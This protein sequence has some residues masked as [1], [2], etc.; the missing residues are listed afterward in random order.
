MLGKEHPVRRASML[1]AALADPDLDR[2]HPALNLLQGLAERGD[3]IN[4]ATYVQRT[5]L[6]GNPPRHCLQAYSAED[7]YSPVPTQEAL[8]WALYL[9]QVTNGNEALAGLQVQETPAS[10]NQY[11]DGTYVTGI[12]ALYEPNSGADGHDVLF[13]LAIAQKQLSHF[14]A[15][16]V[17]DGTPTVVIP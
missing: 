9:D 15:T 6:D 11:L 10:G 14:L 17:R 13:D 16:A 1:E 5:P 4:H 2:W 8:A 12:L 7:S 3:A